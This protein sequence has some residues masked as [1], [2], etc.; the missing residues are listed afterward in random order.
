MLEITT[1]AASMTSGH[2]KKMRV[3]KFF[4]ALEFLALIQGPEDV[5]ASL[6]ASTLG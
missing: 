2:L 1:V 4:R 6:E 3:T 5:S